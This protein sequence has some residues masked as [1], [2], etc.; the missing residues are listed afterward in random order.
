MNVND[1]QNAQSEVRK[2]VIARIRELVKA[3]HPIKKSEFLSEQI[4]QQMIAGFSGIIDRNEYE[5]IVFNIFEELI[6]KQ[7]NRNESGGVEKK[8]EQM[9]KSDN[10]GDTVIEMKNLHKIYRM[11][12]EDVHALRSITFNIKKNE[13]KKHIG[14]I[15]EY[16]PSG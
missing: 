11:V 5:N 16:F 2:K 8:I 6:E 7:R 10:N 14:K 12:A 13:Y 4:S 9:V 15:A 1:K 3:K